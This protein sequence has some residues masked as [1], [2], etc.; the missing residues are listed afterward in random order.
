MDVLFDKSKSEESKVCN[1]VS[2]RI[3]DWEVVERYEGLVVDRNGANTKLVLYDEL[4]KKKTVVIDSILQQDL[5]IT[6]QDATTVW[7][8][9]RCNGL[10][11]H[12]KPTCVIQYVDG[13]HFEVY[14][15]AKGV[16]VY[17]F[18]SEGKITSRKLFDSGYKKNGHWFF[19]NE[20]AIYRVTMKDEPMRLSVIFYKHQPRRHWY[21]PFWKF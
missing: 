18:N 10:F 8:F 5:L 1:K 9:I 13:F 17:F 3:F 7:T 2:P 20:V 16:V 11:L 12:I 4:A 21:W 15:Y 19:E 6:A 14:E